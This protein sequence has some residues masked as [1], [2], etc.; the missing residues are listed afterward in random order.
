MTEQLLAA[1]LRQDAI[2][3]ASDEDRPFFAMMDDRDIIERVLI[4]TLC[5]QRVLAYE[6]AIIANSMEELDGL[7]VRFADQEHLKRCVPRMMGLGPEG[8]AQLQIH[9]EDQESAENEHFMRIFEQHKHELLDIMEDQQGES[10][11]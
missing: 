8:L 9:R 6:M 1:D 4:C 2:A 3:H 5:D 11:D 10:N 7:L